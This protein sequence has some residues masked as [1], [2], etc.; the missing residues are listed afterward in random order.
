M[1]A[2]ARIDAYF[3]KQEREARRMSPENIAMWKENNQLL[4]EMWKRRPRKPQLRVV[5]RTS[6]SA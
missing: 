5:G 4:D 2:Q 6:I 3:A 1:E